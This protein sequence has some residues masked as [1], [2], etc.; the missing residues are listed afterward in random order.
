[1]KNLFEI[2]I[3]EKNRILEM[4][5]SATKKQYLVE[6]TRT[7]NITVK[8]EKGN[9]LFGTF[10][11]DKGATNE[12]GAYTNAVNT[13]I[14]GKGTIQN[15]IGPSIIVHMISYSDQ[16]ITPDTD[17]VNITLVPTTEIGKS[18]I[19]NSKKD[20]FGRVTNNDGDPIEGA[21]I[22]AYNN[23]KSETEK[24]Y[25]KEYYSDVN[26]DFNV[27]RE[28]YNIAEIE[29]KGYQ[30][31]N[32]LDV[33]ESGTTRE[34]RKIIKLNLIPEPEPP[35]LIP[36]ELEYLIGKEFLF[37]DADRK[38][39]LQGKIETIYYIDDNN[40]K[41]IEFT[42]SNLD[43]GNIYKLTFNCSQ[44]AFKIKN[45][46]KSASKFKSIVKSIGTFAQNDF[47]YSTELR[48]YLKNKTSICGW[49]PTT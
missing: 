36:P 43:G 40:L 1:M 37:F 20:F 21:K 47:L 33:S 44:A 12:I 16:E 3:E 18:L 38:R 28:D 27:S 22:F 31:L 45:V 24:K 41:S 46:T 5:I 26:G 39:P 34:D 48:K 7:L 9:P 23:L 17:N 13:D 42:L 19:V 8:D 11:A 10:I 32:N 6:S 2:S 35:S 25:S 49:N 15:F 14:N 29:A 30:K 4:H